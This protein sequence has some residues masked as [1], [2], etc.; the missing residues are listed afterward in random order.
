MRPYPPFDRSERIL[1]DEESRGR[2]LL[3]Q[4]NDPLAIAQREANSRMLAVHRVLPWFRQRQQ[5]GLVSSGI[6]ASHVYSEQI[7]NKVS[8]RRLGKRAAVGAPSNIPPRE[9]HHMKALV[10]QKLFSFA[11]ADLKRLS[12]TAVSRMIDTQLEVMGHHG[13]YK[14]STIDS[15]ARELRRS[16]RRERLMPIRGAWA[17]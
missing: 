1:D 9:L 8:K 10:R 17:E 3:E 14:P 16:V 5:I 12:V 2:R 6:S 13:R 15:F 11:D 7:E 4:W